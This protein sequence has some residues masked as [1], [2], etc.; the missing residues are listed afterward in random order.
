MVYILHFLWYNYI[1]IQ[2]RIFDMMLRWLGN[3]LHQAG[4][5]C[6]NIA[7]RMD[8]TIDEHEICK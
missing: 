2:L 6:Y 5:W 1:T 7:D 4:N 3:K 8:F